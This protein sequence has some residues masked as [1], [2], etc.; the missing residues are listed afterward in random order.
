MSRRQTQHHGR[1]K[2]DDRELPGRDVEGST[3]V[4][5]ESIAPAEDAQEISLLIDENEGY[6]RR[7]HREPERGTSRPKRLRGRKSPRGQ[8]RGRRGGAGR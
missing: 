5:S 7:D 6:D 2:G 3:Q 4:R 1:S 8:A